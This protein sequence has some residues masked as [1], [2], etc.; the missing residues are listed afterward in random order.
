MIG[1]RF[2]KQVFSDGWEVFLN[3]DIIRKRLKLMISVGFV[4]IIWDTFLVWYVIGRIPPL[5]Y[6]LEAGSWSEFQIHVEPRSGSMVNILD[7][8]KDHQN[9]TDD[10]LAYYCANHMAALCPEV[11]GEIHCGDIQEV[12]RKFKC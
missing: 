5:N 12:G 10:S 4:D 9:K 6:G 3:L 2:V 7:G 1:Q 8:L 11:Q